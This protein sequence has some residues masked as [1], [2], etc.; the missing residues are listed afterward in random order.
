V[1]DE[2]VY[3]GL[4]IDRHLRLEK[5]VDGRLQKAEKAYRMIQ[6]FLASQHIPISIRAT[7]FRAVVGAKALYGSEVWGMSQSRCDPIQVLVN[8]AM[9]V[10][11]Q[12]KETDTGIR[13]AAMW[14]E[15][16][17]PPIHAEASARRARAL[18]KYPNLTTWV[19]VLAKYPSSASMSFWYEGGIRWLKR[20]HPMI[21][22]SGMGEPSADYHARA[23]QAYE[24]VLATVWK[25]IEESEGRAASRPY[26]MRGYEVTA[27]ASSQAI[28]AEARPEQVRLGR[29]LRLL[30]L[31]RT[32]SWWTAERMAWQHFTGMEAY[33]NRCPCCGEEARETV[34]HILLKCQKWKEQRQE[35]LGGIMRAAINISRS[36]LGCSDSWFEERVTVVLMLGGEVDGRRVQHWLPS[37]DSYG[38]CGAFQ[39]ARFLQSI[40]S[41][42]RALI[43]HD[44]ESHKSNARRVNARKGKAAQA[45][46][47]GKRGRRGRK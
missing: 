8:K 35:H 47:L 22:R 6:P 37:D 7:V 40:E 12:C 14:R 46:S 17:I 31:C 3:L 18:V 1:V 23:A 15:L 36:V 21:D 16:N 43:P 27:W 9:R 44:L 20:Y 29:G 19:G 2:Y 24:E 26:A 13:V 39:V 30:H 28:P 34:R 4:V 10:M 11:V 32:S 45:K 25:S 38:D 41:S 33:R 42:R 5:M